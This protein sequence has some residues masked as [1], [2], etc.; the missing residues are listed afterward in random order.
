MRAQDLKRQDIMEQQKQTAQIV[1]AEKKEQRDV[2]IYQSIQANMELEQ[3]RR[4]DFEEK[5]RQDQAREERLMQARALE[6]EKSAKASFQTMMRR[7]VIQE[8][9][10]RKQEERRLAILE[11]QEETEMRLLDHEQKKERYLDFKRELDGLRAKNKDINV[12][13]QR[14]REEATREIVADQVRRKDEKIDALSQERRR[15]WQIRRQAQSEAYRARELVKSEIMR[16]RISSKYDSKLLES[17]L[18]SLMQHE[19]FTPKVLQ[20]ST[21]LPLLTSSMQASNVSQASVDPL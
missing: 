6:Q 2:R 16:Q 10:A 9:A 15:L 18:N 4:E 11:Q 19:I 8:E 13:R 14:R 12:E 3:K 20:T 7:K 17:K 1:M 5:Q 21:S